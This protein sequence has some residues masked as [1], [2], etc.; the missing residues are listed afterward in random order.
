MEPKYIPNSALGD[1][2]KDL[3]VADYADTLN[4]MSTSMDRVIE[5]SFGDCGIDAHP[6]DPCKETLSYIKQNQPNNKFN[7]IKRNNAQNAK[8]DIW[9][10]H[11][12]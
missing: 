7:K 6:R 4:G 2:N 12:S 9:Y 5:Q 10:R 1:L 8:D 3:D 11:Q